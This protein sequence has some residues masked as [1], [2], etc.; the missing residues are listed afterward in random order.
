MGGTLLI[1]GYIQ[2]LLDAGNRASLT[3][4]NTPVHDHTRRH[5]GH[6]ARRRSDRPPLLIE[7]PLR[8]GGSGVDEL[9]TLLLVLRGGDQSLVPEAGQILNPGNQSLWGGS[10]PSGVA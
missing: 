8:R 7:R 5:R 4:G 10:R 3:P 2:A 1:A 9:E 6:P